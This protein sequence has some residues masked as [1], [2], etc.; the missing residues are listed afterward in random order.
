LREQLGTAGEEILATTDLATVG[1]LAALLRGRG[2]AWSEHLA[3]DE[4]ILV[5]INQE[6]A[7]PETLIEDGD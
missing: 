1:D 3:E 6:M 2:G 5:A 7:R 4:T